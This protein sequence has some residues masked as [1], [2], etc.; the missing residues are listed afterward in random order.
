[1]LNILV[2]DDEPN[3]LTAVC[4][5]L[6]KEGYQVQTASDGIQ[7]LDILRKTSFEIIILDVMMPKMNGYEVALQIHKEGLNPDGKIIFL[8]AR[9][10]EKDR[11]DG[12]S[13]GGE[14]YIT[15]PFDNH[16]FIETIKEIAAYEL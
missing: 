5:L 12:F 15:K 7:G 1:M 9:G 13:S 10:E 16:L 14:Y 11:Q 3:I 2:I 8:T 6:E 4:Y